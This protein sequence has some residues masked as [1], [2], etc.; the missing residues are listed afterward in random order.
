MDL[1]D[2]V[3]EVNNTVFAY[4]VGALPAKFLVDKKGMIRF[5]IEFMLGNEEYALDELGIMIE[6]AQE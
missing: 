3:T 5:K 1:K 6:L 2:P 4:K